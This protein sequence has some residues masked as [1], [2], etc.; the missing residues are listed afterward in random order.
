MID[1]SSRLEHDL[2]PIHIRIVV[3]SLFNLDE[4][5]LIVKDR[6]SSWMPRNTKTMLGPSV[7]S[8]ATGTPRCVQ[9][10]KALIRETSHCGVSGAPSSKKSSR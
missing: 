6:V 5:R 10:A 2:L 9:Q 7:L 1:S 3:R 4:G 8:G